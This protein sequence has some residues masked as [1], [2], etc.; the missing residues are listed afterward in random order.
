MYNKS[1]SASRG[2]A[3]CRS[4]TASLHFESQA[5][6]K[7]EKPWRQTLTSNDRT[8]QVDRR[9]VK[10]FNPDESKNMQKCCTISYGSVP[11]S[12]TCARL[13]S[14]HQPY[15]RSAWM[16]QRPTSAS[17]WGVH[18]ISDT[19]AKLREKGRR[20]AGGAEVG[21]RTPPCWGALV[22]WRISAAAAAG[23]SRSMV[24]A[25]SE[26]SLA[27]KCSGVRPEWRTKPE[28]RTQQGADLPLST[29][30]GIWLLNNNYITPYNSVLSKVSDHFRPRHQQTCDFLAAQR[31]LCR[32]C[33]R[34]CAAPS[35]LGDKGD[36]CSCTLRQ[37]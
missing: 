34:Q 28:K 22:H 2:A 24:L 37:I 14:V 26:T 11:T 5:K 10:L 25:G 36:K 16:G 35:S 4:A 15:H 3:L 8:A 9:S 21:A 23:C 30:K 27:A 31:T 12:V 7:G 19:E 17:H 33:R 18:R 13:V 32:R 29:V 6:F 20:T 1:N